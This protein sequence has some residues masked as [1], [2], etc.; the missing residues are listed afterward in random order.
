MFPLQAMAR[1]VLLGTAHPLRGGL[2]SYNERL[3]REFQK[4]GHDVSIYTFSLQYP[5]FLFPGKTQFSESEK[6][7]DL[8]I[9]VSVNSINPLNWYQ[10]GREIS[11]LKPDILISK[12]WLPFMGPCLGTISKIV[13]RNKHTKVVCILDNL[14]PHEKRIGDTSFTKYFM[15]QVDA[16]IA[17]SASVLQDIELFSTSIPR[18]L[19]PHP[20]FD[21]FGNS[22]SK[23]EALH[24]LQLDANYKYMLFFGFI[25]EYK[26]LDILLKAFAQVKSNLN[27]VKLIIAGEFYNDSKPYLDLIDSLN[28]RND[29]ILK[30]DFIRDEDV[31]YYFC[32]S[33]IVVQ[34]YKHATQSGV[35]QICYHFNKPMLVTQV[36][37]LAEI[38]PDGKVGYVTQVDEQSVANAL[39]DFF[40]NNREADFSNQVKIEKN[41]YSWS[42]MVDSIFEIVNQIKR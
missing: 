8:D 38:V 24:Y 39:L 5:S 13:K 27:N 22:L 37:G 42:A 35:T 10:I 14:I 17:Q 32:A 21:N 30:T 1:I 23:Q 25:R 3:A 9:K 2:A 40:N 19:S 4:Q 16:C 41:K 34:P 6:P 11:K 15:K 26:G 33:D 28:L 20:I 12:Y 18:K 29:I 36:G 31:R 7:D